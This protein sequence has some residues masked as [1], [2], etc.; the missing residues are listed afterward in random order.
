MFETSCQTRNRSNEQLNNTLL[1]IQGTIL[2]PFLNSYHKTY[3]TMNNGTPHFSYGFSDGFSHGL[4]MD[5]PKSSIPLGC[6]AAHENGDEQNG[7]WLRN[8]A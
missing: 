5:H 4:P 1:T 6:S 2:S 7:G 8:R 3:R